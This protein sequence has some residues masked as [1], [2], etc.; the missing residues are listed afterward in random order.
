MNLK[1]KKMGFPTVSLRQKQQN[2][3]ISTC[4]DLLVYVYVGTVYR[5][6]SLRVIFALPHLQT[7]SPLL[8]IAQMQKDI[9]CNLEF[10]QY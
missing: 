1:V 5:V 2:F 9:I 6:I 8:E 4:T 7:V 3:R 10:A